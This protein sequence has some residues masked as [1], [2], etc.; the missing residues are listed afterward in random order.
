MKC[1][2]SVAGDGHAVDQDR[3]A[4]A[5]TARELVLAHRRYTLEHV[6]QIAGDGDL[7]HRVAD[8]P[9]LHPVSGR[10]A[11]IIAGDH[12]DALSH[13]VGD[14]QAAAHFFQQPGQIEPAALKYQVV[15]A[16]V[17]ARGAHSLLP[18]R[19]G[20]EEIA[21]QHAVLHHLARPRGDAVIVEVAAVS[22]THLTLP[23]NREV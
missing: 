16:A 14:K 15:A 4:A 3:A 18:V 13:Q 22:Y 1:S 20:A 2:E 9:A 7:L 10:A 23:T 19:I 6:A 5:R 8:N 12:V 21:L 11:R 17:V